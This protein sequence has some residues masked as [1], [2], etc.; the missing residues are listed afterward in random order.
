MAEDGSSPNNQYRPRR[1]LIIGGGPAGLVTLR[2]LVKYGESEG[3]Y[4]RVELVERRDDIGGVWYLDDPT[5]SGDDRPR[6]PSPAYPGL[7][8]NVLPEYLSFSFFPFPEPPSA[9]HLPFPTLTETHDYLRAFAAEHLPTGRIRLS[10]NV[11]R[12]EERV[13]GRWEVTLEDWNRSGVQTHEL[14]DAVVVATGWYDTPLYPEVEGL[15]QVRDAGLVSHA[16]DWRGPQGLE[17]KRVLVLGNGN[18]G[19]DIAAH[20]APVALSPVYRSI[21]RPA[22]P[23]FVSLPDNRIQDVAAVQRYVLTPSGK[24]SVDLTDGTHIDNIDHV[25]VGTGY[26]PLPSFV[27]VRRTADGAPTSLMTPPIVP[28]RIPSL[29]RHI[30]YAGNPTLAFIGSTLSYTPF[31]ITDVSSVWLALAWN[32]EVDYPSTVEGRLEFEQTRLAEVAKQRSE[33]DNPS[34]LVSYDVLATF[35]QEYAAK[36]K[37]DVVRAR[38]QLATILPEWNDERTREREAMYPRKLASLQWA[39]DVAN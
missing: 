8:G 15:Q 11:V 31:T 13:D 28:H 6:W 12:V 36:L 17:G 3:R 27:H 23:T 30:L 38:P 5:K 10:V 24:V 14:W 21:R 1:I 20:L 39:R 33:E 2:N 32:G 26:Q 22:L 19:N 16:K 4:D 29:H 37:E 35:E 7:V 25:V 9:P 34:N 18:S